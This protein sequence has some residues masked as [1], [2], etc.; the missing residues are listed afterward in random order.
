[1]YGSLTYGPGPFSVATPRPPLHSADYKC[2]PRLRVTE[3]MALFLPLFSEPATPIL[4]G[5]LFTTCLAAFARNVRARWFFPGKLRE[6]HVGD[7][8]VSIWLLM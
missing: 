4:K 6:W 3:K 8:R 2:Q 7:E 1:M 5:Q